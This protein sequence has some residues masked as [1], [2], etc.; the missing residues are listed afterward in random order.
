MENCV[1]GEKPKDDDCVGDKMGYEGAEHTDSS[2]SLPDF[3]F[4][5]NT[6]K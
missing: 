1:R 3:V 5:M 2:R 6:I 4:S